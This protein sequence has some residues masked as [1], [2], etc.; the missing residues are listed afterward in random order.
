MINFSSLIICNVPL[1]VEGKVGL[2]ALSFGLWALVSIA[3]GF[4]N[5]DPL[6][7]Y[8]VGF[9]GGFLAATILS[10]NNP[11]DFVLNLFLFSSLFI[12]TIF[13]ICEMM[14]PQTCSFLPC[15]IFIFLAALGVAWQGFIYSLI[16][17]AFVFSFMITL[18]YFIKW[19][20]NKT[21]LGMG[22]V[23]IFATIA[24]LLGFEKL[25]VVVWGSSILG[26]LFMLMHKMLSHRPLVA[27]EKFAFVPYIAIVCFF[28]QLLWKG[29]IC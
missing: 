24:S 2:C 7:R 12:C 14:V 23:Q 25:L 1:T 6:W 28:V 18:S 13:D 16:S 15:P 11:L 21:G 19:F 9:I 22:D 27:M 20:Y 4:V 29:S 26:L 3:E 10:W 8:F 17:T 5:K